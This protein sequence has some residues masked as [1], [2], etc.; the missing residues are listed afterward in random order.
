MLWLVNEWLQLVSG[1]MMEQG[2]VLIITF[3]A[4][5]I[6]VVKNMEGKVIEGS[7]VRLPPFYDYST[8][9]VLSL[10]QKW[11][12]LIISKN[13]QINVSS[14]LPL[15]PQLLILLLS[16]HCPYECDIPLRVLQFHTRLTYFRI[17]FEMVDEYQSFLFFYLLFL[18]SSS[19]FL[20]SGLVSS[21]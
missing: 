18:L 13:L 4:F 20:L 19:L 11:L 17:L 15:H 3:Q 1:K 9:S 2:P 10:L 21:V 16:L 14:H 6:N 5:M 12:L 8:Y 7:P